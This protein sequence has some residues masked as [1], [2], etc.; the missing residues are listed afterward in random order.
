MVICDTGT[1]SLERMIN[2]LTL[3]SYTVVYNASS[4]GYKQIL[5][6]TD[7]YIRYLKNFFR[8]GQKNIA[9]PPIGQIKNFQILNMCTVFVSPLLIVCT[10]TSFSI[11]LGAGLFFIF[12]ESGRRSKIDYT[13]SE[14][15]TFCQPTK[16]RRAILINAYV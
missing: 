10:C 1:K 4:N 8:G 11:Y 7:M 12:W 6:R 16:F 3:L 14:L 9:A 13:F 15:M 2:L 5:T